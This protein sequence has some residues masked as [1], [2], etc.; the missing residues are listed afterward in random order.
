MQLGMKLAQK[1]KELGITQIELAER[2]H[3][4]RQ[5]VSRWEAGTVLP[6]VEKITSLASILH[7]T[8][9]YLLRD[10]AEDGQ[11]QT[12]S[13]PQKNTAVSRL[14]QSINGKTVKFSF[15]EEEEDYDLFDKECTV[16]CF[17]G[18]WIKVSVNTKKGTMEKLVA[19]S[20]VLSIDF[21][22]GSEVR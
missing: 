6:D 15:Y 14:R 22:A 11:E 20:S 10:D 3:V 19:L 9:D 1:R 16:L 4:T 8:C 18:N 2:M 21:L 13:T 12:A 17:D 7:V 5:T